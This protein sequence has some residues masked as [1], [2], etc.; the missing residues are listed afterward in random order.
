MS[1]TSDFI[2]VRIF[3]H[4]VLLL[5][6][7]DSTKLKKILQELSDRISV[8]SEKLFTCSVPVGQKSQLSDIPFLSRCTAFP[9]IIFLLAIYLG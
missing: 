7:A 5:E 6:G 4:K 3:R 8:I 2:W 1:S 9:K